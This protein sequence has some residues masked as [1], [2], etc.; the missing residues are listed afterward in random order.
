MNAEP[1]NLISIT[2][3]RSRKLVCLTI[4][5][6]I[7]A[8]LVLLPSNPSMQT[9][10]AVNFHVGGNRHASR[11]N[12]AVLTPLP[13]GS[14][15][16]TFGMDGKVTTPFSSTDSGYAVAIQADGKI[17]V[18]GTASTGESG[19]F[20]VVRYKPDG[21]LDETFNGV[22]KVI[23]NI[24]ESDIANA[25]AIQPDG[26]I[27]VA[28]YSQSQPGYDF[29]LV[30]YNPNGSL[31]TTFD[32]DG[33]V[34]TNFGFSDLAHGLVI[35]PDAKIVVAGST[36]NSQGTSF[37]AALARYNTDGSLDA[38]FGTDGKVTTFET[39]AF[40]I[41]MQPDGKLVPVARNT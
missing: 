29:S 35:Q 4:G 21:S 38:S 23:T 9:N 18:A 27:V 28:G 25:I 22:G 33:K 1:N 16:P 37:R 7:V 12:L 14:L 10:A 15:D 30:R 24:S 39:V 2:K 11:A 31:D 40:A 20:C 6:L 8:C 13:P 3:N 32:G 17:V 34:L 36:S 19:D 5:G 26:K 41:A